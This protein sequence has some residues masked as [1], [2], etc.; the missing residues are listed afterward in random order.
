MLVARMREHDRQVS[1]TTMS[2]DFWKKRNDDENVF[3]KI[4]NLLVI[5]FL[6]LPE[7]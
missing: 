5:D 7:A 1:L 2:G 6:V 3:N 4:A